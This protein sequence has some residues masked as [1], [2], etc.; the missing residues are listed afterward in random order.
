MLALLAL[1]LVLSKKV[2][3]LPCGFA[4]VCTSDYQCDGSLVCSGGTC[5]NPQCLV[6]GTDCDVQKCLV[7][8][9]CGDVELTETYCNGNLQSC[10]NF[11]SRTNMSGFGGSCVVNRVNP[12]PWLPTIFRGTTYQEL[13]NNRYNTAFLNSKRANRTTNNLGSWLSFIPQAGDIMACTRVVSIDLG[14]LDI[15]EACVDDIFPP[16]VVCGDGILNSPEQCENNSHCSA[17]QVCNSSCNCICNPTQP[18]APVLLSP[19]NNAVL[20]GM[21]AGNLRLDWDNSPGGWGNGCPSNINSVALYLSEGCSGNYVKLQETQST[22]FNY[23]FLD[24]NTIKGET[25]YCW[26]T[27]KS[28]GTYTAA[29][30]VFRF[31]TP[32]KPKMDPNQ[33]L[34]LGDVCGN[35]TAGIAGGPGVSNPIT[36]KI[37]A[38]DRPED[39][40]ARIKLIL[41]KGG[42]GNTVE[43]YLSNNCMRMSGS[44]NW[45][46]GGNLDVNSNFTIESIGVDTKATR[47]GDSV[48]L[49]V[50]LKIKTSGTFSMYGSAVSA[51]G[52]SSDTITIDDWDAILS[53]PSLLDVGNVTMTS[54]NQFKLSWKL[55]GVGSYSYTPYTYAYAN[56]NGVS[57]NDNTQGQLYNLSST[58]LSPPS[59]SNLLYYGEPINN[60]N[61]ERTYNVPAGQ[62]VPNIIYT[63]KFGV[64]DKACNYFEDIAS[65][66]ISPST[67]VVTDYDPGPKWMMGFFNGVSVNGGFAGLTIPNTSVSLPDVGYNSTSFLSQ[68]TVTAGSTTIASGTISRFNEFIYQYFNDA[69]K[70]PPGSTK[71]KWYEHLLD[72]A[73]KNNASIDTSITRTTLSGNLSSSSTGLGGPPGSKKIWLLNNNITIQQGTVCDI[74]ALIFVNGN[75]TLN[76]D[77]IDLGTN[78]CMFIVAGNV[79]VKQGQTKSSVAKTDAGNALY[80]ILEGHFIVDGEIKVEPDVNGLDAIPSTGG[81]SNEPTE[82][83]RKNLGFGSSA[84]KAIDY[85]MDSSTGNSYVLNDKDSIKVFDLSGNEINQKTFS[86][87]DT[88]TLNYFVEVDGAAVYVVRRINSLGDVALLKMDLNLN[89]LWSVTFTRQSPVWGTVITPTIESIKVKGTNILLTGNLSHLSSIDSSTILRYDLNPTAGVDSKS[90]RKKTLFVAHLTTSGTYLKSAVFADNLSGGQIEVYTAGADIDSS[91]NV[92]V[93]GSF[94]GTNID[95]DPTAGTDNKTSRGS[96]SLRDGFVIKL[97]NSFGFV[98]SRI[99]SWNFTAN[100]ANG[101]THVTSL[102]LDDTGNIYAVGYNPNERYG[103]LATDISNSFLYKYNSSGSLIYNRTLGGIKSGYT[104]SGAPFTRLEATSIDYSNNNIYIGGRV[105]FLSGGDTNTDWNPDT[106]GFKEATFFLPK[107]RYQTYN[108]IDKFSIDGTHNW[109]G[110]IVEY[111][112]SVNRRLDFGVLDGGQMVTS[113]VTGIS[114]N[115]Y[116][117]LI[118]GGGSVVVPPELNVKWDGLLISG[119]VYSALAELN[120]NINGPGNQLQPA[121][122]F[123]YDPKY[124]EMFRD[125]FAKRSYSI[126][127]VFN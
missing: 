4:S 38:T 83:W 77:F 87:S 35:K 65:A 37:T 92:Y 48:T 80:D 2:S 70:L 29:S 105:V 60:T 26:Y 52:Q 101:N 16:P 20:A 34:V 91:G 56:S 53:P 12:G 8:P 28:N 45:F 110:L 67:V 111:T 5:K 102:T 36:V 58:P 93:A 72:R 24:G 40:L 69:T 30:T 11:N 120:R 42:L 61:V 114:L 41:T 27:T 94:I 3:A 103:T 23:Y 71:T 62:P 33:S 96:G 15:L 81:G 88:Y 59:P 39:R 121:H 6:P 76:P 44:T 43:Y 95:V 116:L 104:G 118:S 100:G 7:Q 22:S 18:G 126:R 90:F 74:Q 14:Q 82:T 1:G 123:K 108:F 49:N 79:I 97:T 86:P 75:L 85:G 125:V 17:N 9:T 117:Y 10:A 78:G 31:R 51:G 57:I 73:N 84:F 119:G 32:Y 46:C 98:W 127:E 89:V 50:K 122:I 47:T 106:A 115:Y 25:D 63:F 109:A 99:I 19:E 66:T 64:K 107:T 55:T 124:I 21:P 54:P 13:V 113:G 68:Y 112:S